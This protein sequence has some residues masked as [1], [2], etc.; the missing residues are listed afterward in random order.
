MQSLLP[1]YLQQM[2]ALPQTIPAEEYTLLTEKG[3]FTIC[4]LDEFWGG[5]FFYQSIEQFLMRMLKTS[6]GMTHGQGITDSTLTKW[7]HALPHCFPIYYAL[8]Q[9]TEVITATFRAT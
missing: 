9:F 5:H 6:G 2:E 4:R 8:E 3:Y 7:G 1:L